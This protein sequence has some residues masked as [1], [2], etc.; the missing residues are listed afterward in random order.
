MMIE[1]ERGREDGRE[2]DDD[3]MASI[4]IALSDWRLE[5]A[6]PEADGVQ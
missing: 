2:R 5:Q 1:D 4:R 3:E 6:K